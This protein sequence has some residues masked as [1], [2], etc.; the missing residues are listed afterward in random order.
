MAAEQHVSICGAGKRFRRCDFPRPL[1]GPVKVHPRPKV[2]RAFTPGILFVF[3][4]LLVT[5]CHGAHFS[6]ACADGSEPKVLILNSYHHGY[7]WSDNELEG[8]VDRLKEVY[9]ELEPGIEFLDM[10]RFPGGENAAIQEKYLTSKY[11]DRKLDLV[12]VLDNPAFDLAM[13]HREE[14]FPGTPIVFAGINDF[15]PKMVSGRAEV[16]GVAELLDFSGTLE[17][18]LALHPRARRLLVINDDTLSG[19]AVRREVEHALPRLRD[20]IEVE[21]LHPESFNEVPDRLRALPPDSIALIASVTTDRAGLSLPLSE[22]TRLI[23]STDVPVYATHESRLGFGIVGGSLLAGRAHGRLAGDIA[24]RILAGEPASSIAIE[25]SCSCRPMFDYKQLARFHIPLGLLP[26]DSFIINRP[27]SVLER[28]YKPILFSGIVIFILSLAVGALTLTVLRRRAAE[29]ALKES[30]G[31]FRRL[32]ESITDAFFLSDVHGQIRECNETFRKMTGY[33]ADELHCLSSRDLTPEKWHALEEEILKEQVSTRG[34]SDVYEKEYRHRDG[35][36]FPVELRVFLLKDEAGTP[37]GMASIVRDISERRRAEDLLRESERRYRLYVETVSEGVWVVNTEQRISY[38]NHVICEMLGYGEEEI[39][40]RLTV[41]F[42]A[43]DHRDEH[44]AKT[45]PRHEALSERYECKLRRKNG[46]DLWV[47]VSSSPLMDEKENLEGS[48]CILNDITE[49]KR[50]EEALTQS[51]ETYRTLFESMSQGVFSLNGDGAVIDVNPAALRMYGLSREEFVA[52]MSDNGPFRLLVHED[53]SAFLDEEISSIRGAFSGDT[54]SNVVAGIPNRRT[55]ARVWAVVNAIPLVRPNESR[56]YRIFIT[57]HD[58]TVRKTTEELLYREQERF[59]QIASVSPGVIYSFCMQP[60]GRCRFPYSSPNIQKIFCFKPE[61]LAEN[62]RIVL[63]HLHD[64]DR[65]RVKMAIVESRRTLSLWRCEFR[66]MHPGKGEMWVEGY[67]MPTL[68]PDGSCL[69][70]GLLTDIT[71]R[72]KADEVLRLTQF[73]VET[74]ADPIYWTGSNARILYANGAACRSLGYSNDE[75]LALSVPDIDPYFDPRKWGEFY[76]EF[77]R[78]GFTSFESLHKRKDGTTF[79]V[80][81][82]ASH[83]AV[84]GHDLGLLFVK[85]LTEKKLADKEREMLEGKLRQA[86]KMEAIGTLAGGIAHDFNNILAPIIG[87]AEMVLNDTPPDSPRGRSLQQILK[88][89]DRAKELVKQILSFGRSTREQD[90]VPT[91]VGSVVKEAL[92]LLRAS[93]PSSIEVVQRIERGTAM[94]DPTQIH[95]V[96]MNLCTNAAH[97]MSDKG[98]L[99]ISLTSVSL[100]SVDLASLSIVDMKPGRYLKLCVS[101]SGCGMDAAV[102]ERIFDPYFTTKAVGK[103]SGLGLSVVHGIVKKYSGAI[104]V[105]SELGMGTTFN[106]YIPSTEEMV[107]S[108]SQDA[109]QLPTGTEK[110]LFIDDEASVVEI[111]TAIL[112]RLGYKVTASRD[113]VQALEIFQ[114]APDQFDLVVTDYTM[115]KL[116]GMDLIERIT[117]IRPGIPMILCTGFTEKVT[118]KSASELGV[119]FMMKPFRMNH[120]AETVRKALDGVKP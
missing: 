37:Y 24:L 72:R 95:Q 104:T 71:E 107:D 83:L 20:R 66:V 77:R 92:K 76:T 70:H 60:D 16:T 101:D 108:G 51:E 19:I 88:A 8:V 115:P 74:A 111:G 57:L 3:L 85:D 34:Y 43:S 119:R 100:N 42:V 97:A 25:T 120:L 87:Y 46:G 44:L 81:V 40:G 80:E 67:A 68:E 35:T 59:A 41:S 99:S 17:I 45:T 75:L 106:V 54:I 63:P 117:K 49:R 105:Q 6:P 11:R 53:G 82:R 102:I 33:G 1:S 69:W 118:S 2:S 5:L 22:S 94:V 64:A 110:I 9:P 18:A 56:P 103:G 28:H 78:A 39:L 26:A 4:A 7:L 30:E 36:V 89:A 58:I 48:F 61:E 21:F 93:L 96:L 31:K 38:V 98:V 27:V 73:S 52:S 116:T 114:K 113:P 62:G 109:P 13:L 32:Y 29:V 50:M 65:E 23:A 86:Q 90:R 55:G 14:I 112:T 15:N 91:E 10:K 84:D 79:P 47:I 12:V